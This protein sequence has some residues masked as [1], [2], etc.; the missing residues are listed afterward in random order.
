MPDGVEL[1]AVVAFEVV[2]VEPEVL[3]EREQQGGPLEGRVVLPLAVTRQRVLRAAAPSRT[4]GRRRRLS[5]GTAQRLDGVRDDSAEK[6]E[7]RR[8]EGNFVF[9]DALNAFFLWLYSKEPLR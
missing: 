3:G 1:A 4:V 2:E 6:L 9:N 8:K 7:K 5:V